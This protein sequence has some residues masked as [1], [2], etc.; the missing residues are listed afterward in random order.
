MR[1][2]ISIHKDGRRR[3][4]H[5]LSRIDIL[6]PNLVNSIAIRYIR[7]DM[8]VYHLSSA[9]ADIINKVKVTNELAMFLRHPFYFGA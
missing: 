6:L 9:L 4:I 8:L 3:H 2:V 5:I 7:S 1:R